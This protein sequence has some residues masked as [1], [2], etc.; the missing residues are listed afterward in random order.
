MHT[1]PAADP[2]GS[3]VV[4]AS[5]RTYR[6][7]IP[8]PSGA[9]RCRACSMPTGEKSTPMRLA[10]IVRASQRPGPPRPQAR[11]T[12]DSPRQ[13]ANTSAIAC[14]PSDVMNEYGSTSAGSPSPMTRATHRLP[15][16]SVNALSNTSGPGGGL[17]L[18]DSGRPPP[19]LVYCVGNPAQLQPVPPQ[20]LDMVFRNVVVTGGPPSAPDLESVGRTPC[21][22]TMPH[23]CAP[24]PLV[25]TSVPCIGSNS[26]SGSAGPRSGSPVSYPACS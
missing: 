15:T 26:S 21:C 8:P 5:A 11:S 18:M 25:G 13:P 9:A 16:V 4:A 7:A 22:E 2:L 10:P 1:T 14:K 17:A 23:R 19:L 3:P 24:P 6:A 12:I 20:N